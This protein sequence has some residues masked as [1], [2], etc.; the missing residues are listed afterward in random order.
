[1][2]GREGGDCSEGGQLGE[3]S[4]SSA[5]VSSSQHQLGG[6]MCRE[7]REICLSPS[8]VVVQMP[9]PT[10]RAWACGLWMKRLEMLLAGWGRDG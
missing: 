10:L 7:V 8:D 6:G 4:M 9:K 1:M 5:L 2:R 3:I